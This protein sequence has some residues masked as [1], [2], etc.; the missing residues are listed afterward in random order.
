MTIGIRDTRKIDAVYNMTEADVRHEGR[1][2]DT[3]GIYPEF[4]DGYGILIIPTT[5]RYMHIPYRS[6]L[7][8]GVKG[9]LVAGR[10]IGGDMV[11]HAA[12]RNMACC[13]VAG[14]GAGVAAAY[15]VKSN[16]EVDT[17]D[18]EAV[19]RELVRQEVRIH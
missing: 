16:R 4:I 5:G 11:A 6:M 19:Q 3:I 8:K 13:A 15:A 14:Q 10:A 9:L 12:T 17:V 18:I 2:E 7:P 1:F